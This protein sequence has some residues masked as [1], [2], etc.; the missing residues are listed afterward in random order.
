MEG[1][2]YR[3]HGCHVTYCKDAVD[4]DVE[5]DERTV[6]CVEN[7]WSVR[8]IMARSGAVVV[9]A[10]DGCILISCGKP[11]Y[12]SPKSSHSDGPPWTRHHRQSETYSTLIDKLVDYMT[13]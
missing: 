7:Y 12:A 13:D 8:G 9:E 4:D 1:T 6:L 5:R 2:Q 3:P 11:G 10:A